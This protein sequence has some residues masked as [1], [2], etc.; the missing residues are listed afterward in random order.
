MADAG[1]KRF[2]SK[3]LARGG[4]REVVEGHMRARNVLRE[5]N[6]FDEALAYYHGPGIFARPSAARAAFG[7]RFPDRRGLRRPAAADGRDAAC[8]RRPQRLLDGASRCDRSRGLQALSGRPIDAVQQVRRALSGARRPLGND[9][10][11]PALPHRGG[12]IS[13]LRGGARLLS[14]ARVPG[15]EGAARRQGRRRPRRSSRHTTAHRR[16]GSEAWRR[17]IGSGTSR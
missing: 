9:G 7:L 8:A 6:S 3:L 11:P 4:R 1:H 10:R 17:P 15:G 16:N 14:F 12:R 5:F 13:K 2:G